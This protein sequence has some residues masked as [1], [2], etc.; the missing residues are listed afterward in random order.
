M[1]WRRTRQRVK[2]TPGLRA[3]AKIAERALG[4]WGSRR[5]NSSEYWDW[6]YKRG[7]NSG[8]GSYNRLAK[9][10]A[11]ILNEFVQQHG[12]GTVI[13][14]GS[15]DGSQLKLAK[16]PNYI[17]V[18][19][20]RAAIER[21]QAL[22]SDDPTR[23]FIHLDDLPDDQTAELV[24]SLDVI[25]HL[26]EDQVFQAHMDRLFSTSQRFVVIYAS[27]FDRRDAMH[28][29]HRK[30]TTWVESNAIEF[31]LMQVIENAYPWDSRRSDDTSFADFFIYEK[32]A[33]RSA[34]NG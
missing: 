4:R 3:L 31:R 22:F 24:L 14:F 9:F 10:K 20:S 33:G 7:G 32:V 11:D 18:D 5:F 12:I 25:Y 8:A 1:K 6:R 34:D 27:N 26:V 21:T 30:F 13:E 28:V 2:Q 23:Q 15:G 29:R 19:V 16:Y 17:G